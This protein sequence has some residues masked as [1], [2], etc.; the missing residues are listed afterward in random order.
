MITR[1]AALRFMLAA[2]AGVTLWSSAGIAQADSTWRDH[3]RA[4]QVARKAKDTVAY[5][6]QLRA[7]YQMVGATPRIVT[8]FASL[9]IDARDTAEASRWMSALAAMGTELD[10]G[11]VAAYGRLAGAPARESLLALH[12]RETGDAGQPASV[13]RLPDATMISEDVAYDVARSR[14]LV[15][16]V[17]R[18]GVYAKRIPGNAPAAVSFGRDRTWG[19]F[20]LGVDSARGVL[21]ATTAALPMVANYTAADSGRSYLLAYDLRTGAERGRYAAPD[22]GAHALGDL[23]IGASGAVYVSDGLGSGIYV[24]EPGHDSLRTLVP[25][26]VLV[27]PQTP[28]LSSD[29]ATLFV[30]DYAIGIA[31]VTVAT[32]HVA[33]LAHSDSL[34]LTGIDGLYRYGRDLIAVQNGLEPNRIERLTLDPSMRRVLHANTVARGPKARSLTHATILRDWLYF[35]RNSGW[36]RVADDGTMTGA[37]PDRAPEVA[38]VHLTP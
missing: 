9:A 7:V 26:G 12:S 35:L 4:L 19:M 34:A 38:R 28:A 2:L 29:G 14:I 5:R 22:A 13:F 24:L 18:G 36:E 30:A 3:E 8:R 1:N 25:P 16:S 15:S 6:A 10:T 21:W 23:T 11:L 33:W 31:A 17:R 37:P 20:A 32:G 27:S